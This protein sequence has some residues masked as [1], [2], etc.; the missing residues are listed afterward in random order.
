MMTGEQSRPGVDTTGYF[1]D[2]Y[3][4]VARKAIVIVPGLGFLPGAIVDQHFIRRERHNR[5]MS[6]VLERPTLVGV[7]I[8]E[9]TALRVDPDGTWGVEGASSAVVYDARSSEITAPGAPVL[10]ATSLRVHLL[11][12]GSVFDPRSGRVQLPKK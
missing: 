12:A 7:G 2:E 3:P 9:G 6:V 4:R 1:G 8:D 10:G 5:L 11:P